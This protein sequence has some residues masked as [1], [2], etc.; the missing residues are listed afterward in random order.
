MI[1]FNHKNGKHIEIGSAKIYVEETGN[2]EKGPLLLL[3][4]GFGNMEDFNDLIPLLNQEYRII[5]ID[6]RGQGKSTLGNEPLTYE[7]IQKDIEEVIRSM[8]LSDS[9][10]VIGVSDGGIVAY[11]LACFSDISISKLITIGSRWNFRN[12]MDT[13]EILTGITP[14]KWKER[15]P[16]TYSAYKS[17]NPEPD[18]EKLTTSLVRMWIDEK[19]SGYPNE[20]V[21]N[22]TCSTLIVRGENDHLV[23]KRMVFDLSE[24][25]PNSHLAHIPFCGHVVYPEQTNILMTIINEFFN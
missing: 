17:L 23:K 22:I 8:N 12:A 6:S 5:G 9:L 14:S 19:E 25:I 11:R 13:R 4:G 24:L 7:R 3:H 10:S 21:M 15:F 16:E 1:G 18:F 20:K 2:P